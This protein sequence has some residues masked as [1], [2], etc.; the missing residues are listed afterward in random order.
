MVNELAA[1]KYFAEKAHGNQKRKFSGEPYVMHLTRVASICIEYTND[2]TILS[3]A[4]LH[5]V[6]EDTSVSAKEILEFLQTIMNPEEARRASKLVEELTDVYTKK[7]FPALNRRE[8]KK[9]EVK[10]LACISENGQTIKYADLIDNAIDIAKYHTDFSEVYLQ[11]ATELLQQM[12]KGN[13]ALY[14][15]ALKTIEDCY[16]HVRKGVGA[17]IKKDHYRL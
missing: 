5:D 6:L 12:N 15:R 3:A 2:I 13:A 8:R 17:R 9:R 4:F 16:G 1:V 10:R 7:N 14:Q 11:E